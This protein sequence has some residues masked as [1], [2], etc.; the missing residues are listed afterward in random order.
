[1]VY[2][3]GVIFYQLLTGSLPEWKRGLLQPNEGFASVPQHL[4]TLIKGMLC[5]DPLVRI[6]NFEEVKKGLQLQQQGQDERTRTAIKPA[7]TPSGK[8]RHS[9]S[10]WLATL[11]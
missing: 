9:R 4:R 3:A 6:A 2:A 10:G 8:K 7:E 5:R 11:L 1:D